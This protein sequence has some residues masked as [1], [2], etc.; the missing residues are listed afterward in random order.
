MTVD[1]PRR[2][3]ETVFQ[4]V[5]D[6]DAM[7]RQQKVTIDGFNAAIGS[8]SARVAELELM[9]NTHRAMLIGHGPTVALSGGD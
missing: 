8:L 3:A 6:M 1:L 7:I 9:V 4:V 2:N 5:K